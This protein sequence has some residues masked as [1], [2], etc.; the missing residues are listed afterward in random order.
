MAEQAGN[1]SSAW[2]RRYC[3]SA[4]YVKSPV[5]SLCFVCSSLRNLESVTMSVLIASRPTGPSLLDMLSIIRLKLLA[6]LS[7]SDPERIP[8]RTYEIGCRRQANVVYRRARY[9]AQDDIRGGVSS[10]S[11]AVGGEV[12]SRFGEEDVWFSRKKEL[13]RK[14]TCHGGKGSTLIC[15]SSGL[16]GHMPR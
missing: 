6:L 9:K 3:S 15:M 16:S 1:V 4:T 5:A 12:E 14:G 7:V 13:E 10:N 11:L 2:F 8:S